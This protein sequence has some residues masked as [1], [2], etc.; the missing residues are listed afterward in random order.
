MIGLKTQ[1]LWVTYIPIPGLHWKK[2]NG[3]VPKYFDTKKVPSKLQFALI[4][5]KKPDSN[6]TGSILNFKICKWATKLVF[7]PLNVE[8]NVLCNTNSTVQWRALGLV[9][10][11]INTMQCTVHVHSRYQFS[12]TCMYIVHTMYMLY[13]SHLILGK[14]VVCVFHFFLRYFK[15]L[16]IHS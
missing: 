11:L 1:C 6:L 7:L 2:H 12:Y 8:R 10:R 14:F 16:G 4:Y 15:F 3:K 9:G 13:W 5:E